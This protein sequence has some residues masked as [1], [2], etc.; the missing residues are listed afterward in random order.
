MTFIIEGHCDERGSIEYNLA[1]GENRANAA[2]QAL[3]QAGSL[4]DPHAHHQLRQGKAVLHRKHRSLLA[5][6]PPRPL[7]V[8]EVTR[9]LVEDSAAKRRA[10]AVQRAG[11]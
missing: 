8:L 11:L 6:E 5:A 1:L 10:L 2:K 4:G 7:R 9:K 3:V